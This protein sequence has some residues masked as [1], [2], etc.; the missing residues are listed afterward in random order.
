MS[1]QIGQTRPS[2]LQQR[3]MRGA[4][5]FDVRFP[6]W[7]DRVNISRLDL[8]SPD[9][10]V[11]A[12]AVRGNYFGARRRFV[13]FDGLAWEFGLC[14]STPFSNWLFG[15][16]TWRAENAELTRHWAQEILTRRRLMREQVAEEA[17]LAHAR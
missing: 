10:C 16:R 13:G 9:R 14:P 1:E 17:G 2:L 7:H 8:T 4:L 3:V 11:L 6:G 15:G 12:Q 5:E